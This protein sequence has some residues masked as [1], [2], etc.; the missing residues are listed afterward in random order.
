MGKV[1]GTVESFER[2]MYIAHCMTLLGDG[3]VRSDD[4]IGL[5]T[6]DMSSPEPWQ[7]E[8][9]SDGRDTTGA[10]TSAREPVAVTPAVV[11]AAADADSSESGSSGSLAAASST[12]R[13]LDLGLFASRGKLR[14]VDDVRPTGGTVAVRSWRYSVGTPQAVS[15]LASG[16]L[17]QPEELRMATR[18]SASA[19]RILRRLHTPR[20]ACG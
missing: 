9:E 1:G 18:R 2:A 12:D 8:Q 15:S 7:S 17:M 14:F 4:S 11:A 6:A 5:D 10:K 3:E 19:G 13:L 16:D 20:D